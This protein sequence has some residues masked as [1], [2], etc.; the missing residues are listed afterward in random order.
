MDDPTPPHRPVLLSLGWKVVPLLPFATIGIALSLAG[1]ASIIRGYLRIHYDVWFE[2]GMVTGQIAFQWLALTWPWRRPWKAR[3]DYALILFAVSGLGALLLVPLIFTEHHHPTVIT[4]L[5]AT[6]YFFAVVLVMFVVHY[7]LVIRAN[8][9][10][11]LCV[12]WV[13][14]RLLILGFVMKW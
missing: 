11:G 3:L 10:K 6:I 13:L 8:L 1:F 12:T 9:P 14:Y 7:R 4:P 5:V 2:L